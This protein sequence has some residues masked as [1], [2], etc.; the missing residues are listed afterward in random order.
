MASLEKTKTVPKSPGTKKRRRQTTS[1]TRRAA[2]KKEKKSASGRK[3]KRGRAIGG[4]RHP[5]PALHKTSGFG[6]AITV[7][8]NAEGSFDVVEASGEWPS[9]TDAKSAAHGKRS[10]SRRPRLNKQVCVAM[11]AAGH[12]VR[13]RLMLKLLDGPATYRA[14]KRVTK[15][16]AG[17]LYHHVN[18]LRLA[19]LILPKQRDLYELTRGG[20]NLILA[21]MVLDRAV[22]DRRRRPIPSGAD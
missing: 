13:A 18:Q 2:A 1:A 21:M 22:H 15:L 6:V 11:A 16:E 3:R 4:S 8:E 14:L 5:F 10:T 12:E 9:P 19:G 7:V 20:R 17:P